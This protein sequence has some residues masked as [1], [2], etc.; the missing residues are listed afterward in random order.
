MGLSAT[1]RIVSAGL[2]QWCNSYCWPLANQAL[3][4]RKVQ[5]VVQKWFPPAKKNFQHLN[6]F[7]RDMKL[8]TSIL[9]LSP[10]SRHRYS[11]EGGARRGAS[12]GLKPSGQCSKPGS[13]NPGAR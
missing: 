6:S 12:L 4:I 10:V 11:T 3:T 2:R 7:G 5:K 9:L 13:L 8:Q 1:L